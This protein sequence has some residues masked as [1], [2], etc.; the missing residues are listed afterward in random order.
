MGLYRRGKTWYGR[1]VVDGRVRRKALSTDRP[2]AEQM[3]QQWIQRTGSNG[4][5]ERCWRGAGG[6]QMDQRHVSLTLRE[7]LQRWLQ[8]QSVAHH[9]KPRSLE[10]FEIAV[11]RFTRLWGD[12]AAE[13]FPKQEIEAWKATRLRKVSPVTVNN[14]L[15]RLRAA[16]RWAQRE[17][18]VRDIPR[19]VAIRTTKHRI[20][21]TLTD[22]EIAAVLRTT[23]VDHVG[24]T[25]QVVVKLALHCGLRRDELRW[26]TFADLDLSNGWVN[27]VE[28]PGWSPKSNAER[29]IPISENFAEWLKTYR[30]RLPHARGCDWVCQQNEQT[31][32]QWNL[33]QLSQVAKELFI[34]AGVYCAGQHTLHRL[35]STYAT[36]VL[37]TG[38]DLESLRSIL[39]HA[40]LAT[41]SLYLSASSESKRRAIAASKHLRARARFPLS[42]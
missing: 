16:L 26:L 14:D 13:D 20:P 24:A 3:L 27:V 4:P 22:D 35:R 11:R 17:N 15:R 33:R 19:V 9:N 30:D 32:Q 39:G 37:R 6:Q 7:L 34:E 28:K 21:K 36:R 8:H 23:R 12:R 2:E 25:M 41:T 40:D 18:L 31:G 1:W 38:G 29:A 5:R 10:T 42:P